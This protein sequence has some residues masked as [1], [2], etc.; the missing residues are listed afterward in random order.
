MYF[1][2]L[3]IIINN[4][5][6]YKCNTLHLMGVYMNTCSFFGH[7]DVSISQETKQ[8]LMSKIENLIKSKGCNIFYFGEF[9]D[10]DDICYK[11]VSELKVFYPKIER[12]YVATDEKALRKHIY[13]CQKSYE[14][15]IVFPLIFNWWYKIIYYRNIAIIDNSDYVIFY[16]TNTVNS[17]AYKALQYAKKTKK[18]FINIAN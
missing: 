1:T 9:G 5:V 2:V 18:Q 12:V 14:R 17:G 15:Q 11:I 4:E 13:N 6:I 3:D 10:F 8:I 7:K 16:V